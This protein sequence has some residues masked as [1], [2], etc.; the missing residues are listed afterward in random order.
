MARKAPSS[1]KQPSATTTTPKSRRKGGY[2]DFSKYPEPKVTA[3]V[4]EMLFYEDIE[5]RRLWFNTEVKTREE[6]GCYDATTLLVTD[7]V[8]HIIQFNRDDEGIPA[9]NRKPIKLYINCPGGWLYEGF[10]LIDA[11]MLSETPVYTYNVGVCASMGFLIYIAGHKRITFPRAMFLHHDGQTGD[12][13][14]TSKFLDSAD[15]NKRYEQE[16]IRAFVLQQTKI[17]A[18][19]YDKNQRVEWYMLPSDAISHG[20]AHTIAKTM[21]EIL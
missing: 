15:F 16:V 12:W 19:L 13:G 5:A 21:S 20:I 7:I 4:N 18:K 17:T 1:T 8:H 14:S 9:E 11:I 3:F 2:F 6:A 10:A